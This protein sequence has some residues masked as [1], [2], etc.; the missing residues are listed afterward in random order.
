M[1][2]TDRHIAY[3][4]DDD[5]PGLVMLNDILLTYAIYN[6]DL[7][8]CLIADLACELRWRA[9]A[10]CMHWERMR[11]CLEHTVSAL[12]RSCVVVVVVSG[13]CTQHASRSSVSRLF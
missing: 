9:L 13:I 1:Y 5:S 10:E 4:A 7:G 11:L 12:P 8:M 6:F 3:Y 2:R